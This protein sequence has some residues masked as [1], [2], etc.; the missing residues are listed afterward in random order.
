MGSKY[1]C[2]NYDLELNVIW[3]NLWTVEIR[4]K[5][6]LVTSVKSRFLCK[7]FKYFLSAWDIKTKKKF[8]T[9][10]QCFLKKFLLFSQF[11]LNL[12]LDIYLLCWS[13][14]NPIPVY[15][16]QGRILRNEQ[17][18][19]LTLYK[20]ENFAILKIEIM[21]LTQIPLQGVISDLELNY[22]S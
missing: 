19:N 15:W 11:N 12:N 22:Y 13:N 1:F 4:G 7:L 5:K 21:F 18:W 14:C 20:M 10:K 16:E 8:K 3:L 2:E 9:N 17:P 6:D